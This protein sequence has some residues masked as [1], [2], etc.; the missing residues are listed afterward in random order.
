MELYSGLYGLQWASMGFPGGLDGKA[1]TW[2]VGYL[3]L[4]PGLG[5]SLEKEMATHSSTLAWKILWTEEPGRLQSVELLRFGHPER[6]SLTGSKT[7]S[8]YASIQHSKEDRNWSPNHKQPSNLLRAQALET[9]WLGSNSSFP[10][11]P[12]VSYLTSPIPCFI[13]KMVIKLYRK[14]D[15]HLEVMIKF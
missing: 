11:Q 5:R 3:G 14:K 13:C 2:N 9:G 1:S 8:H 15:T 10:R 7:I 12:Q 6:L 4:I